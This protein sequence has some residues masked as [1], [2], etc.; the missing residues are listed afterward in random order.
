MTATEQMKL[1]NFPFSVGE[2]VNVHFYAMRVLCEG[3]IAKLDTRILGGHEEVQ[4]IHVRFPDS[5]F[6]DKTYEIGFSC[7]GKIDCA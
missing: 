7:L 3:E 4:A 6:P 5:D 1:E 2:K